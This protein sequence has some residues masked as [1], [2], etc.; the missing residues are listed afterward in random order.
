MIVA[1]SASHVFKDGLEVLV[2]EVGPKEAEDVV[3]EERLV[4]V[5]VDPL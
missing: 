2:F 1:K 5:L 3:L 4:L